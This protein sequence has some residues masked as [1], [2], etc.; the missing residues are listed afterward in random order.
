M[1]HLILFAIVFSCTKVYSQEPCFTFKKNI[2]NN[3]VVYSKIIGV[4]SLTK[5]VLYK[6]AKKWYIYEF[7]NEDRSILS[8]DTGE[9]TL[10]GRGAINDIGQSGYCYTTIYP[11]V[12]FTV[13]IQTKDRKIKI[14]ISKIDI[15]NEN[16]IKWCSEHSDDKDLD[17]LKQVDD[18]LNS[19]LNH[20][21]KY[22][23]MPAQPIIKQD[24]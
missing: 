8:D 7:A 19:Y 24:W 12:H 9:L 22:I 16:I 20:F 6:K 1:R 15:D 14:E 4:D 5:E 17:L 21:W 13:L 3:E 10:I 2:V 23:F 18:R 11:S